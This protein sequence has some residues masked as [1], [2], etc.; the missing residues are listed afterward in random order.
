MIVKTVK[1]VKT[2]KI[3]KIHLGSQYICVVAH[4]KGKCGLP[5]AKQVFNNISHKLGQ[6]EALVVDWPSQTIRAG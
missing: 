6:T 1:T 3:V 2:V 5:L 4:C